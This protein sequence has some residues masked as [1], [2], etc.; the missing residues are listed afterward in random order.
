M[1]F[2]QHLFSVKAIN[3]SKTVIRTAHNISVQVHI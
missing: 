1:V 2:N 3:C